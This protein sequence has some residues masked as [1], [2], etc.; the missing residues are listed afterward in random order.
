VVQGPQSKEG[1]F[2]SSCSL[3]VLFWSDNIPVVNQNKILKC[4]YWT[5]RF[6]HIK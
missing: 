2:I 4:A 3:Y 5:R 1:F 6:V